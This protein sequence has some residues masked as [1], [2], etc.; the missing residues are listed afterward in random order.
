MRIEMDE[1]MLDGSTG[2]IKEFYEAQY[3]LTLL[4]KTL[5]D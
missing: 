1:N 5:T 2:N 3:K 4:K